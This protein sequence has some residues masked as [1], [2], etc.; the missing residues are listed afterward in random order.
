MFKANLAGVV[1]V[2]AAAP[3]LAAPAL[4]GEPYPSSKPVRLVVGFPPGGSVDAIARALGEAM[5]RRLG[6]SVIVENKPGAGTTIAA[7][8]VA[9]SKADGY[10]LYIGGAGVM[11][12]DNALYPKLR[13]TAA[14][15]Q[16]ITQLTTSPMM[17]VTGA[18]SRFGTLGALLGAARKE[19]GAINYS[20]S[21]S[22]APTHLAGILFAKKA[23]VELTHVPFKG[24]AP[25]V[26]AVAS[27][28]ID[29]GFAT[30]ASAMPLLAAGKLRL[31]A[32]SSPQRFGLFPDAPTA[33]ESGVPDYQYATW[34]G[35]FAPA[36]TP[37]AVVDTLFGAAGDALGSPEVS[38]QLASQG[39]TAAPSESVQAFTRFARAEGEQSAQ[40]I[41]DL[42]ARVD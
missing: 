26:T 31:L 4:A 6:Q 35:L 8:A 18:D 37:R 1:A 19:A 7:D 12:G 36:G 39:E 27:G 17:L 24:G 34:W 14:D 9:R 2:I 3:L 33:M 29:I 41:R 40:L 28:D 20:S 30:P 42:G 11:G 21:G 22:G 16:P 15:F 25:S 32:V 38:K 5:S 23:G 13:Y 10:T